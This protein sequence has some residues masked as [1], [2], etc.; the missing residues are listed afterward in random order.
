M[1]AAS[2]KTGSN[3]WRLML[4]GVALVLGGGWYWS[5]RPVHAVR[6]ENGTGLVIHGLR[7]SGLREEVRCEEM[8]AKEVVSRVLRGRGEGSFQVSWSDAK[9]SYNSDCG[10]YWALTGNRLVDMRLEPGGKLLCVVKNE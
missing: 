5:A 3:R 10:Y 8:V 1:A 4:I 6:V 2:T 9:G 7:V